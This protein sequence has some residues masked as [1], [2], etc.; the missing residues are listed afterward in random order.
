LFSSG[1][2]LR[3]QKKYDKVYLNLPRNSITNLLT[4]S[5]NLTAGGAA[6]S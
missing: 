3:I 2:L 1:F 4:A 5:E 6:L